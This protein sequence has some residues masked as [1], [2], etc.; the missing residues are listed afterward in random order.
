MS[1][2]VGTEA[3]VQTA[4]AAQSVLYWPLGIY[5]AAVMLVVGGMLGMSY[6]L[7]QRHPDRSQEVPYESGIRSTGS[8]RVRLSVSFYL[9]ATFFVVFDL[10]SVFVFAWAIA[11]RELGWAAYGQMVVFLG[12][13]A[14]SLAYLWS[15]GALES[16]P[17][18]GERG[19]E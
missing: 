11:V 10:E 18:P 15:Q 8:A 5:I 9:V 6:V 16:S 17:K 13:I 7:G 19:R 3:A 14:A 12:V 2:D 1:Q 4:A